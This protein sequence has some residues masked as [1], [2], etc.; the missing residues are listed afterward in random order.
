MPTLIDGSSLPQI[1]YGTARRSGRQPPSVLTALYNGYRAIDTAS[2][3]RFHDEKLDGRDIDKFLRDANTATVSRSGILVQSKYGPPREHDEPRPYDIGDN[4]RIQV[5]KSVL[6]SASDLG[7]D[8]IDVYFLL[9]PLGSPEET[10]EAWRGLEE[11]VVRGGIRY[12]GIAN[13]FSS[14]LQHL[15][16]SAKIRPRFVQNWFQART[17]FDREVAALCAQNGIVYQIFGVFDVSNRHL[18]QCEP[19]RQIATH[20]GVTTHQALLHVLIQAASQS[21]LHLCIV[22]GTTNEH[23]MQSNLAA[24]SIEPMLSQ[25][26]LTKFRETIGWI[27]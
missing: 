23:H 5:L 9:T 11:I 17:G 20:R 25:G 7:V 18:L 22:D 14:Q 12:L 27:W 4:Y 3:A 26:Q 21:G 13:V 6:Q 16:A 10:L 8:V 2:P 19:V 15:L 24:V 1:I